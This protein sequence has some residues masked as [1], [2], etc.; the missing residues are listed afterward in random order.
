MNILMILGDYWHA[1]GPLEQGIKGALE[2]LDAVFS[3]VIDPADLE[4]DRL[5]EYDLVILSKEG[6]DGA[7]K[8]RKWLPPEGE[9]TLAA[10]V[11]KGG[12]LMGFHSGVCTYLEEGPVRGIMGGHFVS[13]PPDENLAVRPVDPVHPV[14]AD[15]EEFA[16]FDEHYHLDVNPEE[17][18]VFLESFSDRGDKCI[19]GWTHKVG[20]GRFLGLTPGHTAGVINHPMMKKLIFQSVKW[21]TK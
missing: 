19:A 8:A 2:E 12:R 13:H 14:C 21:L 1:P 9:R 6:K 5:D 17:T 7:G 15:I 20:K 4:L 10:Y 3:T 16:V 11:E 18:H